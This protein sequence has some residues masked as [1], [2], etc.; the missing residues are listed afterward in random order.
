MKKL[1]LKVSLSA[2]ME[3]VDEDGQ[4]VSD[5]GRHEFGDKVIDMDNGVL[6]VIFDIVNETVPSTLKKDLK[7]TNDDLELLKR[8]NDYQ[9]AHSY[10]RM[11]EE[12]MSRHLPWPM[13]HYM[14][15]IRRPIR[16]SSYTYP[17]GKFPFGARPG[18]VRYIVDEDM[19]SDKNHTEVE[20][21]CGFSFKKRTDKAKDKVE[22][23][24]AEPIKKIIKMDTYMYDP[25]DYYMQ[26]QDD[27][28]D[29][30]IDAAS[31][32]QG[33]V[34]YNRKHY[35]DTVIAK[36]FDTF[37]YEG[38]KNIEKYIE[39]TTSK[40]FI[41]SPLYIYKIA[42]IKDTA[43]EYL[44]I[45]IE[46]LR[47]SKNVFITTRAFISMLEKNDINWSTIEDKVFKLDDLTKKGETK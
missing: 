28:K 36:E 31:N 16:H 25:T 21:L 17:R 29:F 9:L 22:P 34:I 4:V 6:D 14:Q 13:P 35:E 37:K 12:A 43:I 8:V 39:Y 2:T 3:I 18:R 7:L 33:L 24:A 26:T 44:S 15:E 47:A 23:L 32:F 40:G 11:A 41:Y 27:V 46:F 38:E 42:E 1:K 19:P 30:I 5:L 45:N 20:S 10:S